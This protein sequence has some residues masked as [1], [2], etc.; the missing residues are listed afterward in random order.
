MDTP[1][2]PHPVAVRTLCEFTA[3]AGDLDLRFTPSPTAQ[4]GMAGHALVALRRPAHWLRE[5][6]LQGE[7][8]GLLVRG[9]ADGIDP[10]AQRIEEVKTHRG[11]LSNQPANLRALHWAQARV[12]GAL[13][14]QQQG[15]PDTALLDI[16]LVYLNI[17]DGEETALSEAHTVQALRQH[18]QSLCERY[19]HWADQEHA[20]RRARDR[21]LQDLRFP[22]A[23]FRTGQRELAEACWRAARQGRVLL[24]QASTGIGKTVA[25]VFATLKAMPEQ[26]LDRVF[27]LTAKTSGRQLALDTLQ[28]LPGHACRALELVARD[29]ACEHPDKACHG[30]SCPL[31]RGFYDRL[32]QA[33]RAAVESAMQ[34]HALDKAQ[35]RALALDHQVCPYYLAQELAR[36]SD[37]VVGDYNHWFDLSALLFALQ[38]QEGWKVALLVDEAHNLVD[39]TRGMHTVALEQ[40]ELLALRRPAQPE[41]IRKAADGLQRQWARLNRSAPAAYH[42]LE[43][44]PEGW[45]RALVKLMQALGEHQAE[46]PTDIDPQ[47]QA[48]F[49]NAWPLQTLAERFGSHSLIDLHTTHEGPKPLSRITLRNVVPGPH[50]A[51]RLEAAHSLVLFSATLQPW[52]Y[53]QRLLGLPDD[54]VC[55]D[56]PSPFRAEQ[57]QVQVAHRLSTRYKDRA[58]SLPHIVQTMARQW[59]E[60]PGNYLAFFSSFEFMHQAGEALQAAHPDI[61]QWRQERGMREA[62]QAAFLARFTP[63]GQ[64]IGFAV[65]GGAFGEGIDLPGSRLIGAF[66]ATLGLPQVNPVNDTFAAR[67]DALFGTGQGHDMAYLYPGLQKVV[68]AAGRVIR[69]PQDEG[70][71]HL[72][73][74]RFAQAR[75]QALWPGWWS[76]PKPR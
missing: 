5:A 11:P 58:R 67:M 27:F 8:A 15:L 69:T 35:V 57:L 60:R 26:A 44:W 38:Q 22:H 42:P 30:E 14:A 39:R 76:A 36:W 43:P 32:P 34:G 66:I 40:T 74:D 13:W 10:T 25:T 56:V 16:A 9:R 29:K 52:H 55:L 19:R 71:L 21:A 23:G 37:V 54:T 3:R 48:F 72:M 45:H 59:H 1:L 70:V 33:R 46:H 68:Q 20:H 7:H 6:P 18:F 2:S 51:P 65:L 62:D 75:V 49:L 4:E 73:D 31:A 41:A 50:L 61:P 47:R 12:Y 64:G 53:H 17:D 63:Q 28:Q 24:A